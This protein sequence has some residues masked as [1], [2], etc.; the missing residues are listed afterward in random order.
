M[1][2]VHKPEEF[3]LPVQVVVGRVLIRRA[4]P[5]NDDRVCNRLQTILF[6]LRPLR[7]IV[8]DT[9]D[10]EQKRVDSAVDKR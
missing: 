8:G 1:V 9:I 3:S 7:V 5:S 2:L 4:R 6:F 10:S